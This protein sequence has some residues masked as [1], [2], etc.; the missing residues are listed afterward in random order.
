MTDVRTRLADAI[1]GWDPFEGP[2]L[3]DVLLSLPGI[4]IMD[5][6]EIGVQLSRL[7][8]SHTEASCREHINELGQMYHLGKAEAFREAAVLLATA[9]AAEKT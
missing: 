1:R 2:N 3:V 6:C 7:A 8:E 5:T 9:N 4:A